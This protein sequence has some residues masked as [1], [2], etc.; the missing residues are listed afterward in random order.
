MF[1]HLER[2]FEDLPLDYIKIVGENGASQKPSERDEPQYYKDTIPNPLEIDSKTSR[3]RKIYWY[4][5]NKF[6]QKK[7]FDEIE[8]LRK[9]LGIKVFIGVF[10]GILPL[11]FYFN[12]NPPRASVIFSNMDSWFT[13]V[14]AD[15]KKLWYRKYYSFNDA[16]E[17]ADIVDFLSPYIL[18][19][20]KKLGIKIK[21]ENISIAPCS[22]VDY[23]NCKIGEKK[24]FAVAFCS[25]LEPDKNPMLFLEA[26]KEILK[27]S[28]HVK[29]HILGEGSLVSEVKSFI[30]ENKLRNRIN[31]QFSKNPP[32][33]FAETSVFVS[34]QSGTN[35]PSQSV[36]EAMACGNAVIA[37]NRGDTQLFINEQN[38]VL[39]DL[40]LESVVN[41]IEKLINNPALANKLGINGRDFVMKNHTIEKA[42]A[43]YLN[44]IDKAY[45]KTVV[46]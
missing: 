33:I 32:E 11:V 19:G 38:G 22:F 35:Y 46:D 20:I 24:E 9:S 2:M 17:N 15:M 31:F 18:D 6:K 16:L 28:P 8:S 1:G 12:E 3:L 44:L 5:K 27:K 42:S 26:A 41:A 10:S 43:Y 13:D 4:Y 14:H 25:R 39:V 37:S 21:I 7:V 36:L 34:L 30:T 45:K 29:F 40:K 23:S